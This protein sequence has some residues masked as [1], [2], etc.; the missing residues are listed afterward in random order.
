ML[1]ESCVM[2]FSPSRAVLSAILCDEYLTTAV[3]SSN[4]LGQIAAI[5]AKD[6]LHLSHGKIESC[7]TE[8]CN[9]NETGTHRRCL[10]CE[11]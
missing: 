11:D 9:R 5:A 8:T 1:T 2:F 6:S 10:F 7:P 4:R 3:F